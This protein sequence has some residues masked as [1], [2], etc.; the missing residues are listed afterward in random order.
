MGT[1]VKGKFLYITPII[2]YN[3]G[4]AV[5]KNGKGHAFKIGLGLGLGYLQAKGNIVF[6]E[7][8][9]ETVNIDINDIAT[10]FAMMLVYRFNN[11]SIRFRGNSPG[12]S[13]EDTNYDIIESAMDVRYIFTF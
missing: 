2:F 3:W 5:F 13:Y 8:T 1:S 12:V 4:D 11:V 6:T 7:T 9:S 10:T